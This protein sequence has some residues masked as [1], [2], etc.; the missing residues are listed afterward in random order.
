MISA[1]DLP[2]QN[3][4]THNSSSTGLEITWQPP[5]TTNI[6]GKLRGYLVVWFETHAVNPEVFNKT[7]HV[8]TARR[9]K[10][11]NV[12]STTS[13]QIL[14]LDGLKKF[15]MYTIRI[16]A[17]T[18][19]N[20]VFFQTNATTAEDGMLTWLSWVSVCLE[21]ARGGLMYIVTDD[22]YYIILIV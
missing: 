20:G 7:I 11:R 17:F 8:P 5:P 21:E 1:P 14:Y 18:I 10:R 9:R 3:V 19:E 16:Q 6:N 2:P 15:T 13:P 22:W 12:D 4:T